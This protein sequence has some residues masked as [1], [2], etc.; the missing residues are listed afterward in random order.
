MIDWE[1]PTGGYLMQVMLC[2]GDVCGGIGKKKVIKGRENGQKRILQ[3][4]EGIIYQL[5][6]VGVGVV[7]RGEKGGG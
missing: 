1:A 5:G 3:A 4:G 2:L 7:L 6:G